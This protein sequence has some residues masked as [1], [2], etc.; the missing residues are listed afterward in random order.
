[1]PRRRFA[2]FALT[3]A[4][5]VALFAMLGP[6]RDQPH[7]VGTPV[8]REAAKFPK[9]RIDPA[10]GSPAIEGKL[11]L[12]AVTLN[13]D[14]GS[15]TITID[16]VRRITFQKDA[17]SKSS[18]TV[19]L[20]DKSILRGR[21]TAEQFVLEIAG[22]EATWRKNDIREIVIQR[23]VP[24]SWTAIL[25]GLLTLTRDGDHS[26]RRQRHLPGHRGWQVAAGAAAA[27]PQARSRRGARHPHRCCSS[28]C[29]SCSA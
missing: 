11:K 10:D 28:R 13:T 19:Q 21:V 18:D 1:M 14:L 6:A 4:L 2:V 8:V 26:R 27:R 25:L 15:T 20:A 17:A 12:A 7:S 5:A 29:R 22:G 24:L 9:A 16:H 23:E 3:S